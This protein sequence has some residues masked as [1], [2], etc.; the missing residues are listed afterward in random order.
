[1]ARSTSTSS[2][3]VI[4]GAL[5]AVSAGPDLLS[6][7]T[8]RFFCD[9]IQSHQGQ[10]SQRRP[11]FLRTDCTLN[12]RFRGGTSRHDSMRISVLSPILSAATSWVKN[13]AARRSHPKGLPVA[14]LVS[15]TPCRR[16]VTC[17]GI[18]KM[19][20]CFF[21]KDIIYPIRGAHWSTIDR[22][23]SSTPTLRPPAEATEGGV[24]R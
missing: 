9:A 13:T 21:P 20:H 7:E 8:S 5:L 2:F 22:R 12:T 15:T 24:G 3:Q 19:G 6:S 14:S 11:A 10:L 1:M 17:G 4:I 23:R 16:G 18:A